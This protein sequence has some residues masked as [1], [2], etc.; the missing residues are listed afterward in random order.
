MSR[1]PLEVLRWRADDLDVREAPLGVGARASSGDPIVAGDAFFVEIGE[2]DP[3]SLAGRLPPPVPGVLLFVGPRRARPTALGRFGR[4]FGVRP[5]TIP[6]SVRGTALLL[7]GY[8]D[9]GGAVDA[10]TGLDLVWGVG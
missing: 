9:I 5:D 7:A 2:D 1:L 6:R 10:A 3:A 4:I 8:R